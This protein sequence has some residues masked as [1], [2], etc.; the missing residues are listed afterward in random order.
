MGI[1]KDIIDLELDGNGMPLGSPKWAKD[2]YVDYKGD[3]WVTDTVPKRGKVIK[4]LIINKPL[5]SSVEDHFSEK[6]TGGP[7][8]TGR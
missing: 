8:E 5:N 1:I 3:V 6:A 2:W 7:I 4:R